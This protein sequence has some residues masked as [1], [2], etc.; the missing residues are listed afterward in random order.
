MPGLESALVASTCFQV[1]AVQSRDHTQ[2]QGMLGNVVAQHARLRGKR[3]F[4]V[5]RT[6][7][8]HSGCV[9]IDASIASGLNEKDSVPGRGGHL[10]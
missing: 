5:T 9:F 7:L 2:L 1:A 8:H 10:H 4:G 3:G 6:S